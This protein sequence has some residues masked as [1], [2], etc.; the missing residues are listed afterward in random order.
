MP[1]L[2]CQEDMQ[3]LATICQ[4]A[5]TEA[6]PVQLPVSIL[7]TPPTP[8]AT[9]PWTEGASR[10]TH[11]LGCQTP[12]EP[13]PGEGCGDESQ[14]SVNTLQTPGWPKERKSCFLFS[15]VLRKYDNVQTKTANTSFSAHRSDEWETAEKLLLGNHLHLVGILFS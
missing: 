12:P 8:S 15:V 3:V 9:D 10:F 6:G 1:H 4:G 2:L 7:Y 13:C 11:R 5:E 14:P